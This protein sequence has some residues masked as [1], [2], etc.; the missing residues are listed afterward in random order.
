MPALYHAKKQLYWHVTFEIRNPF[1]HYH[2]IIN[3]VENDEDNEINMNF[4][5]AM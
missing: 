2:M 1:D 3:P 4:S 5:L